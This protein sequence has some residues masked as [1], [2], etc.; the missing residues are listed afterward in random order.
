MRPMKK[1]TMYVLVSF[2]LT[3]MSMYIYGCKVPQK[4]A[5]KSGAQLWGENCM[6]CHNAPPA[7]MYNDDQWKT[8]VT[9]MQVRA[10][11]T[12]TEADKVLEFLQTSNSN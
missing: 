1:M 12:K 6:R 10:N 2:S 5:D 9:H 4:I 8:I 3:V 11:I 7:T